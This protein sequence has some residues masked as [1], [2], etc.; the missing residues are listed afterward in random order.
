MNAL[1]SFWHRYQNIG[2]NSGVP[3][4]ERRY[5]KAINGLILIVTGL[6]W[7]QLPIIIKLLPES[8]F[9][10]A[11]FIIWPAFVQLV[12]LLN[13]YG[14]YTKARLLYS[15]STVV[16]ITVNALQMGPDSTNNLFLTVAI[17]GFFIIFPPYERR[18]LI[19]NAVFAAVALTGLEIFFYF[20]DRIGSLPD[21]FILIARWS[22]ISAM[23]SMVVGITA[24]HYKVVN[25]A[26]EKLEKEFERSEKLL[27]NILPKS[28]AEKLK[29]EEKNISTQIDQASVMFVDLIGFTQL[30]GR[31]H[32]TR[33]V[34]IL[35]E[36]F[37]H[38]DAIVEKNGL[39]K[40][41]MIG[42]A[43][44]L[45]GGVP[46]PRREHLMDIGMCAIEIL[47]YIQSKPIEDAQ[48]LGVR[49]GIHCGPVI[50]GVICEKKFAYDLWG[51]T[52]NI[53]SRME[54][55]GL[56]NKIQVSSEFYELTKQLFNYEAREPIQIKGKGEMQTYLMEIHPENRK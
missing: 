30:S 10:L 7:V 32:H 22:S 14:H 3:D 48:S 54:S 20:F 6:L 16:L 2:I 15:F 47:D 29:R 34:S 45:A 43:Y 42:D 18:W 5:V 39:E 51:D 44:M 8:R 46:E 37:S 52:V 55:H 56:P 40:I 21:E 53:A 38:F 35:N 28:V 24:Y 27:L 50:A 13:H 23:V 33:V 1:F 17:V 25:D 41:K 19:M 36:L 31:L 11:A 26:E 9:I 49:I 12:P 4:R